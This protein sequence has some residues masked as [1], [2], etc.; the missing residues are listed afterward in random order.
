MLLIVLAVVVGVAAFAALG[1]AIYDLI[2]G[3]HVSTTTHSTTTSEINSFHFEAI[4]FAFLSATTFTLR[5]QAV[6]ITVAG[7]GTPGSALDRL[8]T[9]YSVA[10]DSSDALYIADY[11]NH[12]VQKFSP[13]SSLGVTVA[14]QTS[15]MTGSSPYDLRTPMGVLVDSHG[16]LYV[17][18]S[19]NH[20]VQFFSNGSLFGTTIAG[21]G[22]IS[23]H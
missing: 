22:R 13:G 11:S 6:G 18:D 3:I 17:S 2:R 14:G 19:G 5:W 12:R 10:L 16:N 7:T 15:A 8:Y 1:I 20:R 4:I 21:T 23:T 9:P